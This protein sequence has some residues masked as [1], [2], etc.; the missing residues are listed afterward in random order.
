MLLE[1][2]CVYAAN[3]NG[4]GANRKKIEAFSCVKDSFEHA[5][6]IIKYLLLTADNLI[7]FDV[8]CNYK[9]HMPVINRN[10]ISHDCIV[11]TEHSQRKVQIQP[12]KHTC[13]N[14][15]D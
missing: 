8:F 2:M 6:H 7:R 13:S 5:R 4:G 1:T 10:I 12:P 15:I 3:M 11:G 14:N 9:M